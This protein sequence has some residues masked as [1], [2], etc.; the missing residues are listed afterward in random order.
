MVDDGLIYPNPRVSFALALAEG[1]RCIMG[2]WIMIRWPPILERRDLFWC[3]RSRS[4]SWDQ[5]LNQYGA[6]LIQ[7]VHSSI[8]GRTRSPL[9]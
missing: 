6:D 1:V 9:I 2:R 8:D 3:A 5:P 4:K 7:T